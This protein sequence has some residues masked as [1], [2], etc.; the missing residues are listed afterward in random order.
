VNLRVRGQTAPRR[1]EALRYLPP[2]NIALDVITTS[3]KRLLEQ[4][5]LLFEN[6]QGIA[7]SLVFKSLFA[8]ERLGSTGVGQGAA[9][10]H[11]RVKGLRAPICAFVR[12]KT[13]VAF[14]APDGRPVHLIFVLLVPEEPKLQH[15][16][17]MLFEVGRMFSDRHLREHLVTATDRGALHHGISVWHLSR[18][19]CG[20]HDSSAQPQAI[21]LRRTPSD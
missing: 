5:G 18:G 13:P 8:R 4:L 3:K 17:E 2:S 15:H 16:S 20:A 1:P 10:P 6:N 11:A 19:K 14:N 21:D 12:L 7:R 9:I